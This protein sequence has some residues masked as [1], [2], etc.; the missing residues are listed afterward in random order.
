MLRQPG[1]LSL[2]CT[3]VVKA[4]SEEQPE[5]CA[6]LSRA[7]A[8]ATQTRVRARLGRTTGEPRRTESPCKGKSCPA[9]NQTALISPEVAAIPLAPRSFARFN[10]KVKTAF[11]V[12]RC[13]WLAYVLPRQHSRSPLATRDDCT[14]STERG[15]YTA[16]SPSHRAI[17]ICSPQPGFTPEKLLSSLNTS[18]KSPGAYRSFP[19]SEA[20]KAFSGQQQC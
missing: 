14:H 3:G 7:D 8:I 17:G 9:N 4:R 19:N 18:R 16:T 11:N 12:T 10:Q 1:A 20:R 13:I 2:S 5:A 15:C 6:T